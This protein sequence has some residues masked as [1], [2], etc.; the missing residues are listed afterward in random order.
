MKKLYYML[1]FA[2]ISMTMVSCDE[3]DSPY[4]VDDIVGSWESYYGY[5]GYGEYDIR[6]YDVVRYDFYSDHTGRFTYYSYM[7]LTYI[8]FDWDTSGHRLKIW[9]TNGKYEDLYYGF[10]NYG[11]LILSYTKR[12][13]EYEV[14]RPSGFYYEQGKSIDPTQAKSFDPAT[15]E[16]PRIATK[17]DN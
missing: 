5:D 14:F 4:Y 2:V 15:D 7:G 13:Y 8:D 11:Y 12:F 17:K 10:D 3:W 1:L 16:I 9:Y 6:G